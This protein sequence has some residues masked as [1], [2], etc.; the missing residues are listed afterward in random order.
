MV[1]EFRGFSQF[2]FLAGCGTLIIGLT[3]FSFCAAVLALLGHHWPNAPLVLVGATRFQSLNTTHT[4]EL[5]DEL[6]IKHPARVLAVWL[7]GRLPPSAPLPYRGLPLICRP[8]PF[9]RCGSAS[10]RGCAS[11]TTPEL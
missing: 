1:S 5:T 4:H 6:H 3:M 7:F 8:A 9:Q 10:H 11:I 2:G